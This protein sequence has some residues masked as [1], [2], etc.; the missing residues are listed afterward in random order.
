MIMLPQASG[1]FRIAIPG[2]F[3]GRFTRKSGP[4]G[5]IDL[6]YRFVPEADVD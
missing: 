5:N 1:T 6:N 2:G 4:S 3:Y